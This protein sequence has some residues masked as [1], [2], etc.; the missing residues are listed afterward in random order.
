ML[1]RKELT[2][3]HA[4]EDADDGL[5]EDHC[6]YGRGDISVVLC[7]DTHD[8]EEREYRESEHETECEHALTAEASVN[9]SEAS[10]CKDTI[11]DAV[12]GQ[13]GANS[14]R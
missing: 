7:P 10:H 5:E 8:R 13:A 2:V 3:G 12:D 11:A 14:G 9:S 6:P 4:I 1:D